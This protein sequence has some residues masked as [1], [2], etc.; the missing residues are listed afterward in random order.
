MAYTR[1]H[2][3]KATI[4]KS[5]KY[6]CDPEKTDGFRLVSRECQVKCVSFFIF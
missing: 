5:I 6:I 1:M 3:I 2:A 4:G